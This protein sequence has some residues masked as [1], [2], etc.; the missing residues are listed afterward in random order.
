MKALTIRQPWADAIVHLAENPKRVE[1]RT[2]PTKYR[3]QIL[4][5]AGLIGDRAAVLAG[6]P[7]GPDKRGHII[8]IAELTGCHAELGCCWPWG[9]PDRWH[10]ELADVQPLA[11]PVP[12]KGQ[13]GLWN[14][15]ADVLN[16][17]IVQRALSLAAV[18]QGRDPGE[19]EQLRHE[20]WCRD[21]ACPM[22]DGTGG[23]HQIGCQ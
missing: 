11:V 20:A 9:L 23:D 5:H 19:L 13:L 1:N 3:G 21:A 7:A 2:R 16:A 18:M 17:V 4:I 14:P 10:W 15:P 8:G 6:V 22:C 12:A